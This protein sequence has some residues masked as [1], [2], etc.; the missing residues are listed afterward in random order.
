MSVALDSLLAADTPRLRGVDEAHVQALA[1]SPRRLPPILVE[2]ATM[3]IIDGT[4]RVRAARLRGLAHIDAHLVEV[5]PDAAFVLAVRA[6]V[7]HGLPL[8]PAERREAAARIIDSHPDWSDRTIAE[9]SGLAARTVTAVRRRSGARPTTHRIGH[10]GRLRPVDA[11][12]GRLRAALVLAERPTASLR[13]LALAAGV[14]PA[15]ARDVRRR[16]ERG[17]DPVPPRLRSES[18][19]GGAGPAAMAGQD[20]R[21]ALDGLARDP[22]LRLTDSGRAV[23]RWIGVI[24]AL[25]DRW[26]T[27]LPSIPGECGDAAARVARA[28]ALEWLRFAEQ[29][30]RHCSVEAG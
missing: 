29:L 10:D 11:V 26:R 25:P 13:D 4:H 21:K 8:S 1:E 27:M 19:R 14:A 15:T 9:L 5:P 30:E 3:R 2:A 24:T 20:L 12:D 28:H 6:N 16:L 23:L 7:A 18:R 22:S 17:E